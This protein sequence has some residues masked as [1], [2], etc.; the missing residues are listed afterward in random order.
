[1]MSREAATRWG[2]VA[3]AAAGGIWCVKAGS[4]LATGNQPALT[5]ELGQLLFPVGVLGAF[6]TVRAPGRLAKAGAALAAISIVGSALALV[7]PLV[8]GAE[9]STGEDFVFP[10]SLFVMT[11]SL[12]AFTGLFLVGIAIWRTVDPESR[13]RSQPLI[14][15]LAPLPLAVTGVVDI[16]VPILGIGVTWLW[17]AHGLWREAAARVAGGRP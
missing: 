8:P 6:L 16:E 10:Y 11:G 7:Y 17:L 12:G 14:V 3:L 5:F 15:S 9:I 13:W 1:M 2:A 4:I